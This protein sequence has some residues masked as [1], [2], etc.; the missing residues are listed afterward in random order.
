MLGVSSSRHLETNPARITMRHHNA[1]FDLVVIAPTGECVGDVA[2][3]AATIIWMNCLQV[4][5]QWER[6][7]RAPN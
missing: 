3:D 2:F 6:R 7:R 4:L 5:K 1:E